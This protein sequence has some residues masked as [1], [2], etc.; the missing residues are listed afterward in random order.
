MQSRGA[1]D[2]PRRPN[3]TRISHTI[4]GLRSDA[5]YCVKVVAF[6]TAGMSPES[7]VAQAM[8]A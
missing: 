3:E 4:Q 8:A 5:R 7:G 6:G 2:W 1:Y